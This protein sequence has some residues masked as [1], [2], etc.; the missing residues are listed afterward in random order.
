MSHKT[1]LA[2]YWQKKPVLLKKA[3]HPF[4]DIISPEEVLGMS[5]DE[6]VESRLI[7]EKGGQTP[8]ETKRGPFKTSLF[9]KLPPSHWTILVNGVDRFVPSVQALADHFSFIPFWRMD[10]IMI[11]VAV[12]Q[13][14]VG[15]HVDNYDVFLVQAHG[16][17]EWMIE[18]KPRL[19]D[20]FIPG[21]PIRLLK[22]FKP[23]HRWILEPGDIL[24]LPPRIPHHGIARGD[25]CMTISVGFR[26]PTHDEILNSLATKALGESSTAV[27]YSDP[28][29]IP[30]DPGEISSHSIKQVKKIVSDRLL[31][32]DFIGDWLGGFASETY[33]DVDLSLHASTINASKLVKTLRAAEAIVRTEGARFAFIKKGRQKIAFYHNGARCDLSARPA[34]LAKLLCNNIAIAPSEVIPYLSD[35]ECKKLLL[36]LLRSGALVVDARDE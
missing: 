4:P 28:N 35:G 19:T 17:R 27:R 26:A 22:K 31:S 1:F 16:R 20:D 24:Y 15:A 32:D 11:S 6:R 23:T 8:W 33:P 5:L 12:D 30:Q 25:E 9:K 7:R 18:D 10:D 21:L 3:L 14:N 29:L 2:Q 13:G 34:E 36:S